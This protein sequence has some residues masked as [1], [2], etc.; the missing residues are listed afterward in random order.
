[1]SKRI[2]IGDHIE[3]SPSGDY[4]GVVT[5]VGKATVCFDGPRRRDG[6]PVSL[7][8]LYEVRRCAAPAE[9]TTP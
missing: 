9:E 5:S 8:T 3:H 4:L 2:K 7:A 6:L 1:V